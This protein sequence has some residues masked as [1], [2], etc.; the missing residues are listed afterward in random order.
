[1]TEREYLTRPQGNCWV[2][3]TIGEQTTAMVS[4]YDE[5]EI[6]RCEYDGIPLDDDDF[7]TTDVDEAL[8]WL[9]AKARKYKG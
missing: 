3:R 2:G 5:D 4:R 6:F 8:S 9:E 7:E 1:M